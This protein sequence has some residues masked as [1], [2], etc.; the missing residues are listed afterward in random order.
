MKKI[1][2]RII[3][4][5]LTIVLFCGMIVFIRWDDI[6]EYYEYKNMC[7]PEELKE[8]ELIA[9]ER[10]MKNSDAHNRD[11][12]L[13]EYKKTAYIEDGVCIVIYKKGHPK[14]SADGEIYVE[15]DCETKKII[16]FLPYGR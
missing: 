10:I 2:K 1:F 5:I 4:T 8:Y 12:D 16:E 15:I 13:S 6:T 7:V 14:Y 11:I 3:I 9:D